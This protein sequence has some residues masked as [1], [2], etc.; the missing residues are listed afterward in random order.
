MKLSKLVFDCVKAAKALDDPNFV[1][2]AFRR[3]DFDSDPDYAS[4]I[5]N[6]FAPINMAVH[7]LSDMGKVA[8]V[9]EQVPS[10]E[11]GGFIDLGKLSRPVKSV[12]SVFYMSNGSYRKAPY[13]EFGRGRI[14]LLG[15]VPNE[16]PFIAY[17]EDIPDFSRDD[18]R[19]VEN[20]DGTGTESDIELSDHG[21][22]SSMC[23]YIVEHVKGTLMEQIAPELANMHLTRAEQ[24]F[25]DLE[26][27]DT[28]FE[29]PR[30]VAES[31]VE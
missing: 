19:Y 9:V 28:G 10:V 20:G 23:P 24:Y 15:P 8:D 29:Q 1:Y 26:D 6:A 4:S 27:K 22:D 14:A 11:S 5:S 12:T 25:S 30:I 2:E 18:F 31:R 21:I 17:A 7:R 16:L 13:R 3:G